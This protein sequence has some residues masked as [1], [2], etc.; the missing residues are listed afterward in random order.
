[1][2][3]ASHGLRP[4]SSSTLIENQSLSLLTTD[5]EGKTD[6]VTGVSISVNSL[7]ISS[8]V[9]GA[10]SGIE[11]AAEPEQQKLRQKKLRHREGNSV[12]AVSG[13]ANL[14]LQP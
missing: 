7:L 1:M 13:A 5:A 8:Q 4:G 9:S 6:A 10:G 12:D 2:K 14:L 11:A 3:T